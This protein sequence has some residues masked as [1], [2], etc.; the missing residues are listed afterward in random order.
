VSLPSAPVSALPAE[1]VEDARGNDWAGWLQS[2]RFGQKSVWCNQGQSIGFN[3]QSIVLAQ[4]RSGPLSPS[5]YTPNS[6][7]KS[8]LRCSAAPLL[9]RSA[10]PAAPGNG[11]QLKK[12]GR[13]I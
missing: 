12:M 7:A 8:L 1:W 5:P 13:R 10:P 6:A 3:Q 2:V 9:R 11:K 4:G